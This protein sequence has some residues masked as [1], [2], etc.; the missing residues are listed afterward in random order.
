LLENP[1]DAGPVVERDP[2]TYGI[3]GAAMQV[4]AE[5]GPGFLEV[6]YQHALQLEF[7]ARGIPHE[8]E[9]PIAIWYRGQ[10]LG[11]TYRADFRCHDDVLVELKA[12]PAVG[13]AEVRQ[14]AHYLR[15]S[16]C[17]TG[18]LLNF[19]ANSLQFQRVRPRK[20]EFAGPPEQILQGSVE[21]QVPHT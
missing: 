13:F 20:S 8:R 7:S 9:V 12:L 15:A 6:S 1:A 2:R 16:G 21:P 14:L 5:L 11:G 10:Q 19:G 17:Q 4:H 18:L 3:I